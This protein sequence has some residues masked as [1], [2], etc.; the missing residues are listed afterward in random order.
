MPRPKSK[1]ELL[2]LSNSKHRELMNFIAGMNAQQLEKGF[3]EGTLNRSVGDVLAHL[4][5][6]HMMFL[7]WYREGMAGRK[8]AMPAQGFSWKDTP[9]LNKWIRDQYQAMPLGEIKVLFQDSFERVQAVITKHSDQELF[10]KK[11]YNWTG[12]TSLGSYLVS[13]TS[14]HYDWGLKLIK[15]SLKNS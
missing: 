2:E 14:S 11:K 7:E 3:P 6:W 4:H 5:H 13:A 12:S 10:E 15:I 1:T 9:E 8:P